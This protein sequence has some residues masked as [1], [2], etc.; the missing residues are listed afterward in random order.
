MENRSRPNLRL[1]RSYRLYWWLYCI[2]CCWLFGCLAV[3]ICLW[4]RQKKLL[5]ISGRAFIAAPNGVGE[6]PGVVGGAGEPAAEAQG[7]HGPAVA[8][9]GGKPSDEQAR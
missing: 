3:Q 9:F 6:K 1:L 4:A 7:K 8:E 5:G 2:L